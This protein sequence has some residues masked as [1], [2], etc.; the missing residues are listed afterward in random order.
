MR[1]GKRKQVSNKLRGLSPEGGNVKII[2]DTREQTPWSFPLNVQTIPGTLQSGDYSIS[3][4][5]EL[6]SIER[7]SLEDLI[8]CCTGDGRNRFKRE[9]LRLRSFRCKAVII[10]SSLQTILDGGHR[11]KINSESVLGSIT[12]WQTRYGVP[13]VFADSPENAARYCLATMRTFYN[14]CAEFAKQFNKEA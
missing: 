6:I 14:R 7:K 9:L 5:E 1:N 3:G 8:G 4:L 11:S 12:S 10:E 2:I 13:F